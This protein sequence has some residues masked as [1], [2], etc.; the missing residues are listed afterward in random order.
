MFSTSQ[1][2]A[3][4]VLARPQPTTYTVTGTPG[5]ERRTIAASQ[6]RV[7]FAG[8]AHHTTYR[9]TISAD[10]DGGHSASVTVTARIPAGP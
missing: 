9:F 5:G 4:A 6:H 3:I 1:L 8:L 7:T 10:N 2:D